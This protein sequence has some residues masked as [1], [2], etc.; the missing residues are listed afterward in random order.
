[1]HIREKISKQVVALMLLDALLVTIAGAAALL[2]RFEFSIGE[3]AQYWYRTPHG[4]NG[5]SYDHA[6]L[7]VRA[8]LYDA[9]GNALETIETSIGTYDLHLWF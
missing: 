7:P 2:V 1:M 5:Y 3:I 4:N 9:A 6:E 8:T